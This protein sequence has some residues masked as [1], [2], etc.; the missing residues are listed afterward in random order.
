[1][2]INANHQKFYI[3]YVNIHVLLKITLLAVYYD[4]IVNLCLLT[5]K[6]LKLITLLIPGTLSTIKL[7]TALIKIVMLF[8][9]S[10]VGPLER[11]SVS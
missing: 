10:D 11:V 3:Y 1:M 2:Q 8:L 5:P 6:I 9:K 4:L 7:V